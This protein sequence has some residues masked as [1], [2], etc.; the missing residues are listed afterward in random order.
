MRPTSY[1]AIAQREEKIPENWRRQGEVRQR[2]ACEHQTNPKSVRLPGTHLCEYG[3][4]SCKYL[5][6]LNSSPEDHL[7]LPCDQSDTWTTTCSSPRL[8]LEQ[9]FLSVWG[10]QKL[11]ISDETNTCEEYNHGKLKISV[12]RH[13]FCAVHI[14]EVH[15]I[16]LRPDKGT[17][18]S[19]L[20]SHWNGDK[21]E[22]LCWTRVMLV[23]VCIRLLNHL[24][25]KSNWCLM[26]ASSLCPM[27]FQDRRMRTQMHALFLLER[28]PYV[29]VQWKREWNREFV[30]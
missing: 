29:C 6:A 19:H 17:G 13:V 15:V 9:L 2:V 23:G 11:H 1:S 4:V 12:S 7:L 28:A 5:C 25:W 10:L 8:H 24:V 20:L 21:C 27:S 18:I 22:G 30:L 26:S 14:C 3:M 16:C